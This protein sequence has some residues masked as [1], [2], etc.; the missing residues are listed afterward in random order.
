[1][2]TKAVKYLHSSRALLSSCLTEVKWRML[3]SRYGYLLLSQGVLKDQ[4]TDRLC[5]PDCSLEDRVWE[6][7]KKG[8][9]E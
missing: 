9:K 6:R 5:F 2:R 8:K 3:R 4:D 7:E 1:M